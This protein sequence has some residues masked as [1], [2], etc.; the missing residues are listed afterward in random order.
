MNLS[1]EEGIYIIKM[2]QER[3]IRIHQMGT[4]RRP[5]KTQLQQTRDL[6]AARGKIVE[7]TRNL[8]K[9]RSAWKK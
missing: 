6:G 8:V 9:D 4:K 2:H 1:R 3:L 7:E 5:R